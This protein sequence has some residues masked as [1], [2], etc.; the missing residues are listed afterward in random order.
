MIFCLASVL[1]FLAPAAGAAVKAKPVLK[2]EKQKASYGIGVSWARNLKMHGVSVDMGALVKGLEDGLSGSKLLMT[3]AEINTTLSKFSKELIEK[4]EK[5]EK[6]EALKNEKAGEAFLA[7]NKKE[8][9]VVVLPDGLQYKVLKAGHGKKPGKNEYAVVYGRGTLINGK[10]F[11][12]S[13]TAGRPT[14][15]LVGGMIRGL[16]EALQMMPVGSK[17]RIFIPSK[18][19]YGERRG[20]SRIIGPGSTLIFDVKLVSIR[21]TE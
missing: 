11:F 2:T 10:V 18:L 4:K 5:A 19:A 17:W 20:G 8:K 3:D 6:E 15:L 21:K 14:P 13:K 16:N 7:A 12:N 9:G 1:I